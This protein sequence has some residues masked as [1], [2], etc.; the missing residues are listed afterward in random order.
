MNR[1]CYIGSRKLKNFESSAFAMGKNESKNVYA[2][3]EFA[4]LI[5]AYIMY[6]DNPSR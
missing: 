4:S 3:E 2:S 1:A 5:C 6:S